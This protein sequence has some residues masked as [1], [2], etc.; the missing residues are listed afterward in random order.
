MREKRTSRVTSLSGLA[1]AGCVVLASC[2]GEREQIDD[3]SEQAQLELIA[4]INA[5]R[6]DVRQL[7]PIQIARVA[8]KESIAYPPYDM[9]TSRSAVPWSKYRQLI[10]H[11]PRLDEHTPTIIK[12]D[13]A[14]GAEYTLNFDADELR[15]VAEILA[16]RGLDGASGPDSEVVADDTSQHKGW[17]NAYDSRRRKSVDNGYPTT[18][19]SLRRLGQVNGGCTGALV[20]RRLVLT[21]AHCVVRSDLTW[22]NQTYR[23]R[24]DGNSLPYGTEN[25]SVIY[26]DSQ[27]VA[28]NCHITYNGSTFDKC[29]RWDWAVMR[30]RSNAWSGVPSPGWMGFRWTSESALKSYGVRH[31]GYPSCSS[32]YPERPANCRWNTAYGQNFNCTI[33]YFGQPNTLVGA[34]PLGYKLTLRHGC[35]MSR[36]HSGGPVYTYDGGSNGPY[37]LG[38]NVWQFCTTCS[39]S[40][41]S[42]RT[43]PNVAVRIKPWLG[44][45]LLNLRAQYP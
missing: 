24:R 2:V 7:R 5:A 28:N 42:T 44:Q 25:T 13:L 30:L 3:S 33:N 35:D 10:G 34:T 40:S 16:A 31:E 43:H 37:V 39:G 23:A 38:I 45:F 18:E 41:G 20:G 27:W 21:A 9:S 26:Y 15:A 6:A 12:V 19:N 1:L 36:G 4:G 32:S 8:K 11:T 17:S 14:K 29:V 22:P